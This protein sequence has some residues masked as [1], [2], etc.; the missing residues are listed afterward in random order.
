MA[1]E[2]NRELDHSWLNHCKGLVIDR[3]LKRYISKQFQTAKNMQRRRKNWFLQ[4]IVASEKFSIKNDEERM[5]PR[6]SKKI[7]RS[8]YGFDNHMGF[9]DCLLWITWLTTVRSPKWRDSSGPSCFWHGKQ[10]KKEGGRVDLAKKTTEKTCS[11]CSA[12]CCCSMGIM[13]F[14][15]LQILYTT[16]FS[17]WITSISQNNG[18]YPSNLLSP[19]F[20]NL[21]RNKNIQLKWITW[22]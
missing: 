5:V 21:E 8:V 15:L 16:R 14:L 3:I 18:N 6:E 7:S 12:Y 1:E 10:K 2:W 19:N 11:C 13:A 4:K 17:L 20:E 22:N 9:A